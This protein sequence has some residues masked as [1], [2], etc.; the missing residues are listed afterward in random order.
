MS[1]QIEALKLWLRVA[2]DLKPKDD[3][4]AK[5]VEIAIRMS[6]EAIEETAK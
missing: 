5:V 3:K 6:R 1:K 2:P 4:T